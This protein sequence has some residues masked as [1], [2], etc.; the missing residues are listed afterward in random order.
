GR[1]GGRRRR[2]R[3]GR[4]ANAQNQDQRSDDRERVD[5][6]GRPRDARL[7]CGAGEEA[8]GIEISVGLLPDHRYGAGRRGRAAALAQRVQTGE[9][10]E[11]TFLSPLPLAGEG[12]EPPEAVSRER[13]YSKAP[14]FRLAPLG[15]LSPLR[16]A[17]GMPR[18][19][20]P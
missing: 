8:G 16:G 3:E 18:V 7:L 10:D 20:S 1:A 6:R 2:H 14:L 11:L 9:E 19:T 13:A 15:T 17:R 5:P 12:G 4:R